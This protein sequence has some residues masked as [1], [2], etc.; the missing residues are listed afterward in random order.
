MGWFGRRRLSVAA[1]AAVACCGTIV[2]ASGKTGA[3]PVT[4]SPGPVAARQVTMTT[5]AGQAFNGV[6]AVGALFTVS[7]GRLGTHF[8][9]ASVVHSA[10]GDLAVTAAHCVSGVRGQLAFVPEYANG[11]QLFEELQ[12]HTAGIRLRRLHRRD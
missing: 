11:R 4:R 10:H 9:T 8:C 3:D 6:A 1:L 7:G 5:G 12:P 2:A